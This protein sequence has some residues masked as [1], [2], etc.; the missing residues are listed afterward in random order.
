MAPLFSHYSFAIPQRVGGWVG[1]SGWLYTTMAHL[2]MATHLR[3]NRAWQ[4]VT[5]LMSPPQPFYRPFSGTTRVSW[6]QKKTS[7]LH[8]KINR[9]RHI[10]HLAGRHSIWTNQCPPPPSPNVEKLLNLTTLLSTFKCFQPRSATTRKK[11]SLTHSL[12]HIL[13]LWAVYNI[14]N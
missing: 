14:F 13:Y 7:G 6:C 8:G 11:H 5:S 3:T 10:D 1:L 12:T 9:G 4:R 2:W